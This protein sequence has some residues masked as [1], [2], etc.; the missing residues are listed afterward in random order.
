[1]LLFKPWLEPRIVR[2]LRT[3]SRWREQQHRAH[4]E[5]E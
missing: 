1:M 5:D 4:E 2:P 3:R